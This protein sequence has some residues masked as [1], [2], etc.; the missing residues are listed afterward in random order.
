MVGGLGLIDFP[1]IELLLDALVLFEVVFVCR[2]AWERKNKLACEKSK[3]LRGKSMKKGNLVG[4]LTPCDA[5]PSRLGI[6]V[7]WRSSLHSLG[8]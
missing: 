3:D 8:V 4:C 1:W 7:A 2:W 6:I 5:S